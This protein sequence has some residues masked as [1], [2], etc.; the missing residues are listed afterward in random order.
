MRKAHAVTGTKECG[1]GNH[2]AGCEYQEAVPKTAGM[3]QSRRA[4]RKAKKLRS[5]VA[6]GAREG[7]AGGE[8]PRQRRHT[9]TFYLSTRFA[10]AEWQGPNRH[11]VMTTTGARGESM[12]AR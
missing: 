7:T 12:V 3:K 10:G 5:R 6:S 2:K 4:A 11:C 1:E 8:A 9:V